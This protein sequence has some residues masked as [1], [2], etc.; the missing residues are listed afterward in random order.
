MY[1]HINTQLRYKSWN[2][3]FSLTRKQLVLCDILSL[4]TTPLRV[5]PHFLKEY[6]LDM[7]PK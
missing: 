5:L 2:L 1:N 7:V 6:K 4:S 3:Y